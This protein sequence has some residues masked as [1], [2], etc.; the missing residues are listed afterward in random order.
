M[1]HTPVVDRGSICSTVPTKG[2]AK[3]AGPHQTTPF[4]S[5][6]PL[7][8]NLRGKQNAGRTEYRFQTTAAVSTLEAPNAAT[9]K[10]PP[11][12]VGGGQ[13]PKAL[14]YTMPGEFEEHA[15]CWM[16]WP[17]SGYL[18]RDDAKPAQEQYA[19]VAKAISQFE[20]V[21][22][23]ANPESAAG[24]RAAF[25]DAPNVT[26]VEIPINDGWARDWGPSCVVKDDEATGKRVVAG[27]HWDFDSYGGTIKKQLGM[28][29]QVPDWTKDNAAGRKILQH[30]DLEVFESPLHLEGGSIHSDG[31]GTLICTEQCL[32]HPS[33]N[34]SLGQEGIEA[35]LKEYLGLEKVIWLWKGMAGDD[36]ITNGHV[37]NLAC[38]VRPGLVLLSWTDDKDD[39]QYEI[40]LDAYNRLTSTPDAKGR[41]IEVVKVPIPYPLFRTYKEAD[42]LHPEHIV[43]GYCPRLPGERLPAS[44]INH[45]VANGGVVVPQFGG[46]SEELDSIAIKIL[47]KAY[48]KDRKVA[49]SGGGFFDKSVGSEFA[50]RSAEYKKTAPKQSAPRRASSGGGFFDKSVGSEFANRSESP[51]KAAPSRPAPTRSSAGS[52]KSFFDSSVAAQSTNGSKAPEKAAPRQS[53]PTRASSGGGGFF[54]SSVGSQFANRS[55]SPKKAA[56]APRQSLPPKASSGGGFFDSSVGSQFA[57]RSESPKKAA[58]RQSSPTRASSRKGFFDGSVGSQFANRSES[59]RKAAPKQA[60]SP[61]SSSGKGFFDSPAPSSTS[62]KTQAFLDGSVAAQSTNGS[63]A[64]K[65]AAPK[66]SSPTKASSG[67]GFFDSSVGSQFAN[68]SESPK[69]GAP[70][71]S[72]SPK[73]AAPSRPAPTRSASSGSS[74]GFFDSSVGSEFANKSAEYKKAAP[75]QS[76]P[77]RASSGGGFFDKSVGSEFANRRGGFF[78]SSVGSQ[79]ANRSESP[80]KAAP[81]Q[82]AP[83]GS[84]AGASKGFFDSSV[85]SEFANRSESPKKAA[86]RQTTPTRA[87]S[88]G[89]S[90]GF[91]DSSVGSQFA[92]R[93]ESPKKAAPKQAAPARSAS[94]SS[95]GFFDSS[96][97]SQSANRSESPKKAAPSPRQSS[98]TKASSGGG[99]F[100][101]SVGSQF[102]TKSAA[103]KK[104]APRQAAPAR[105]P[106]PKASSGG[107]GF[108][109]SSVGSQ[110][111][112]KSAAP[113]KAAPRQAA[114]TSSASGSSK[115]FFDNSV[116]SQFATRKIELPKKSATSVSDS[117]DEDTAEEVDSENAFVSAWHFLEMKIFGRMLVERSSKP[118]ASYTLFWVLV[119]LVIQAYILQTLS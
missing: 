86:P 79:F 36:A 10:A 16:G 110:F 97:G 77:R 23:M 64:P 55:E 88:S 50:N 52:T 102:A 25:E 38:F 103:P 83:T 43:K 3:R 34:P 82:S 11:A 66:E 99:F 91:F 108:F 89:S 115:G 26:V 24:A 109:D 75:K 1:A 53:S 95:K 63:K 90:K 21:V 47:Q 92:N 71:R 87:S 51:K 81:K 35:Q 12:S 15:N 70:T 22:M 112:T 100:D 31:Q 113:A 114:R 54:D 56:P 8:H 48:G 6:T 80:K 13:T 32:L 33:R 116:G 4:T 44:Y 41:K 20:P 118:E 42:G 57:N 117:E 78:D 46:Y 27:T 73:K 62:D 37:D 30:H 65:K 49:S 106:P 105:S 94:G 61:R 93:S 111:T 14:G 39:P 28:P 76:A 60:P 68:R 58:P 96:V 9:S 98:P 29:T 40:S 104:A 18:W 59:P 7:V 74:K 67:G 19:E 85:G 107:G 45:Y 17:D 101:S 72:E 5:K 119:C 2:V 84:S 69:K